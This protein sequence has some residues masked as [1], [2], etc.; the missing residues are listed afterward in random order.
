[1]RGGKSSGKAP[2]TL[3]G[4]GLDQIAAQLLHRSGQFLHAGQR[5][6]DYACK[7]GEVRMVLA[8]KLPES[9]R[10]HG[11]LLNRYTRHER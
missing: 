4:R 8:D 5:Q 11:V 9:W 2:L 6:L 7:Q 3:F 10:L 1:M